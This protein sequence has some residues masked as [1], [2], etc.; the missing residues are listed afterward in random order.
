MV[1]QTGGR[2][3]DQADFDYMAKMGI[4]FENFALPAVVCYKDKTER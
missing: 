4:W 2:Y 3:D 1:V